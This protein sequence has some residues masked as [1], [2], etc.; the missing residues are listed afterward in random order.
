[1]DEQEETSDPGHVSPSLTTSSLTET[2]QVR[3]LLQLSP[4]S[5]TEEVLTQIQL[6]QYENG[7]NAQVWETLTELLYLSIDTPPSD[8]LTTIAMYIREAQFLKQQ[9]QRHLFIIQ[10]LQSDKS[11]ILKRFHINKPKM[12]TMTKI[13]ERARFPSKKL[14][15]TEDLG[16]IDDEQESL[17]DTYDE[18]MKAQTQ[19]EIKPINAGLWT[20]LDEARCV[21]QNIETYLQGK[22][23]TP[24]NSINGTNNTESKAHIQGIIMAKADLKT[25]KSPVD[26]RNNVTHGTREC[27]TQIK[28]RTKSQH[29]SLTASPAQKTGSQITTKQK[30]LKSSYESKMQKLRNTK[31]GFVISCEIHVAERGGC[32]DVPDLGL[33]LSIPSG[34]L[35]EGS[36]SEKLV[37]GL[38]WIDPGSEIQPVGPILIIKPSGLPFRKPLAVSLHHNTSFSSNEDIEKSTH[39]HSTNLVLMQQ[40]GIKSAESWRP[41]EPDTHDP[42]FTPLGFTAADNMV[43]FLRNAGSYALV[44]SQKSMIYVPTSLRVLVFGCY[45]ATD[46]AGEMRLDLYFLEDSKANQKVK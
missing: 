23:N 7:H 38:S 44:P 34:A 22:N 2:A 29:S 21:K 24:E 8:V 36:T 40:A 31:K 33:T 32:Y 43:V 15:D 19:M 6:L 37:V 12:P 10:K 5:S 11:E 35:P 20:A 18:Q 27:K 4:G 30:S 46:G 17:A 28:S 39:L 41:V 1:M 26:I 42:Y 3:S 25:F 45:I 16:I 13:R 14:Q 9:E